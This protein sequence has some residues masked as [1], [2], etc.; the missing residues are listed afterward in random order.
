MGASCRAKVQLRCFINQVAGTA[1]N[2]QQQP[3]TKRVTYGI[4][5]KEQY[6]H[7][8]GVFVV[9]EPDIAEMLSQW[10]ETYKKGLLTF[11]ML[12]LL[13]RRSMYAYEMKKAVG[14][15]SQGTVVAEEN[16][17]YRALRRFAAAGLVQSEVQPSDVGPPRRYF[18]LTQ[19]G[20]ELL[21]SFIRRNILVF[22]AP[23]VAEAIDQVVS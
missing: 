4:I 1:N 7:K 19:V 17:I 16:S 15:Y 13:E 9:S 20:R 5:L 14:D 11:W 2:C 22:Q 12:L 6:L 8:W 21:A 18:R 10:E 23:R 3:L